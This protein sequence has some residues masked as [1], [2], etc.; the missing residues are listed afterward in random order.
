MTEQFCHRLH[1]TV[2]LVRFSI[3][4]V[5]VQTEYLVTEINKSILGTGVQSISVDNEN[6]GTGCLKQTQEP[7]QKRSP[8]TLTCGAALSHG[9]KVA[10]AD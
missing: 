5:I 3:F 1:K 2:A 6:L 4:L 7:S 10:S 9:V 8:A